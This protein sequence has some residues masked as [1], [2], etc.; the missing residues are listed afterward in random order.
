MVLG[1]A[2]PSLDNGGDCNKHGT[3]MVSVQASVSGFN[4][5]Q[6]VKFV[7]FFK[8]YACFDCVV[9]NHQKGEIVTNTAPFMLFRVIL[10]IE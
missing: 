8:Y 1:E 5:Y 4:W 6:M 3:M 9:I 10:V 2:K 7:N